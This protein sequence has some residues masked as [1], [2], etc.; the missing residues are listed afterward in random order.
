MLTSFHWFLIAYRNKLNLFTL[1][2]QAQ[3]DM[4]MTCSPMSA[5]IIA[6]SGPILS[7]YENANMDFTK[8]IMLFYSFMSL[9]MPVSSA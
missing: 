3:Y 5:P 7:S 6:Q 8:D 1:V 2:Y 9:L 4:A